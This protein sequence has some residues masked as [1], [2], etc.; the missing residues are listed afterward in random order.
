[1]SPGLC[2]R[3]SRGGM[4]AP[5]QLDEAC[6]VTSEIELNLFSRVAFG[7]PSITPVCG[8]CDTLTNLSHPLSVLINEI[9]HFLEQ[10]RH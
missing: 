2:E 9:V 10:W 6:P 3:I 8:L 4:L 5:L 1:M 7:F